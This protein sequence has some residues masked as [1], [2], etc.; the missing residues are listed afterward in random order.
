MVLL[1]IINEKAKNMGNIYSSMPILPEN[2]IV[3]GGE[4]LFHILDGI[5]TDP[6][7]RLCA[8]GEERSED[9]PAHR[10]GILS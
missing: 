9:Y 10:L 5:F 8:A 4:F 7:W 3:Y 1:G 2:L 6:H